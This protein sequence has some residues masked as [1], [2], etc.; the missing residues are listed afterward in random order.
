MLRKVIGLA[1]MAMALS[2]A[3]ARAAEIL[4]AAYEDV[5]NAPYYMG[6]S[7]EIDAE[8]PGISVEMMREA[9]KRAGIEI[10]FVRM[11]WVRCLKSLERGE[12][13]AIFNSS[14]K[15]DRL[16]LGV[17]PMAAGKPDHHRRIDTITY[18][19]YRVKGGKVTFNGK[20]IT[21]LDGPVG[22]PAGYSIL[23]DLKAMG[24]ATEEAPDTVINFK[25]LASG[26]IPA[27]AT[28][29]RIGDGLIASG[30][31][32]N[33]EK[34]TPVLASK[35]YFVQVSHQLYGRKPE[36]VER[37]WSHLAEVRDTLGPQ[38]YAKYAK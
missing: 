18:A 14:F 11:P 3:G 5:E 17:Y 2:S 10:K 7:V 15:E 16:P 31:F 22:A 34:V 12:V 1:V 35:D 4:R 20:A 26:R 24:V 9:A 6:N 25:K 38:L 13:D 36:L 19:L 37:L 23:T 32:P 21:G 29:E 8:R 28:H 30:E 27:V 33:L